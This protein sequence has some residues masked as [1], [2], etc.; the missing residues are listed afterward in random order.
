MIVELIS[1]YWK[2]KTYLVNICHDLVVYVYYL[3]VY[4]VTV[5]QLAYNLLFLFNFYPY[6]FTK[7]N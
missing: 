2:K 3:I 6:Y 1:L 5:I 7:K 4:F